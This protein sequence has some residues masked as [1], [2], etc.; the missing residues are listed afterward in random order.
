MTVHTW[1]HEAEQGSWTH[2]EWR[3]TAYGSGVESVWQF[4]GALEGRERFYPTGTLDLLIQLEPSLPSFRIVDDH[5]TAVPA[6]ALTGLLVAPLVVETPAVTTSMMGVRLRPAGVAALF[7]IPQCAVTGTAVSLEDLV[8]KESHQL[9][10]RLIEARFPAERMTI[11]A[12]WISAR[13][14]QGR[15]TDPQVVHA[16]GDIERARGA[17]GIC[18]LLAE[19]GA[20]PR[21]FRRRFEEQVGVTP[22]SFARIVRFRR[23]VDALAWSDTPLHEVAVVHGYYDQAH[24]NAE[25]RQF[26]GLPPGRFRAAARLPGSEGIAD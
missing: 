20:S 9:V 21:R 19:I 25:F 11:M 8:G 26:A 13:M 4:E 10:D 17:M 12:H 16:V 7:D 3:P 14:M 1:H 23:T 22:K 15:G 24:M 6:A 18:D 5:S 2:H